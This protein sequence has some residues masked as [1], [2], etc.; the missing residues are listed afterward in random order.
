VVERKL[1]DIQVVHEFLDVFPNELPRM[2]PKRVIEF[3]IELQPSTT[4]IAKAPYKMSPIELADLKIQLQDLLDKCFIHPSSSPWG[5][6]VLFVPK[7]DKELCLC[8]DYRP[9]NAVTIKNKYLLPHIDI[10]FD[11]LAGA[12]MFSKIDLLSGY[13]HIRICDEDIPKTAF[14][15]RYGLY[16]YLVISFGLTNTPTHFMYLMNSVFMLELDKFVVVLIDDILVYSKSMDEHEEHLRVVLQRLWDHQLYAMFS[17]CEFWIDE[18]S[19]LGHVISPKGIIVDPGKVRDVLDWKPPKSAHQARSF[20]GLAGYYRRFI[21]NFSKISKLITEVLKKDTK[22]VWSKDCDEAFQ[23]LKKLLTTSLVLA[24]PDIAKPFDV[25]CDASGT[26]LGGVLMQEGRVISYSSWQ[27]RRHKENYP[28]HDLELAVVVMALRTWRHYLLGNVVH[29]YT[30]HKSLKYI[31][32]QLDLNMRQRR[33]LELIKDYELELHYHPGKANI[34][35]DTLSHKAHC[36]Y[37]PAVRLMG[38]ESSTRVLP[39]LSL[40]NITLTP[41]LRGEIIAAQRNM[42]YIK[43]RMQEGD[44]KV[45]CFHEDAEEYYGSRIDWL[46]RRKQHSRRWF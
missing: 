12:Q 9:L 23:T 18:V 28:T 36:N 34:V 14:S 22:Y 40:Y 43:R 37:L 38:E 27:L 17:R 46:C 29:I 5:C 21:L 13:H 31:F 6:P 4:P 24:Q 26:G 11:Q 42:G 20:L 8:V 15:M 19:F 41:V 3:K 35:A 33:R 2:P 45:A 7:K 32:T 1:Q 44:P 16:E 25:Y 10:L 30:N 39:D